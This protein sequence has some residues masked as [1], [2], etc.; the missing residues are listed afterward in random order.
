MVKGTVYTYLCSLSLGY[1]KLEVAL[2]L[3]SENPGGG[4]LKKLKSS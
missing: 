2:P 1:E 4:T 3:A